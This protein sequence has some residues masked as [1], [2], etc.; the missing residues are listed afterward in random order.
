[1]NSQ[2]LFARVMALLFGV[3]LVT[4]IHA[5]DT[6]RFPK[7]DAAWTVEIEYTEKESKKRQTSSPSVSS[8][9]VNG[10]RA[11]RPPEKGSDR[12]RLLRVDVAKS[13]R[14]QSSVYH[15]MDGTQTQT[16]S[17]VGSGLHAVEKGNQRFIYVIPSA[18]WYQSSLML[19]LFDEGSF[20]WVNRQNLRGEDKF[21]N[22][23][24]LRHEAVIQ[25]GVRPDS[26][27][28][29]DLPLPRVKHAALLDF[30]TR[31]P[32]ALID[33]ERIMRF[34]FHDESPPALTPPD[35]F[36]AALERYQA[37]IDLPKPIKK[38]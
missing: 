9:S 18:D 6:V 14:F 4:S 3:L 10:D 29:E 27:F 23:L 36:A 1:M 8:I 31:R 7:G 5:S 16:W 20:A 15:W 32:V 30:E 37:A 28:K 22:Q 24:C 12:N 33:P 25:A 26:Q 13:G 35:R 34:T 38:R 21:D 2:S 19:E 11:A 17:L